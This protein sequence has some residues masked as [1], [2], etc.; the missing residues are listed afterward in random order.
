M[1]SLAEAMTGIENASDD[2]PAAGRLRSS[3]KK[4]ERVRSAEMVEFPR[5]GKGEKKTPYH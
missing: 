4:C 2:A 5:N 1:R 3:G